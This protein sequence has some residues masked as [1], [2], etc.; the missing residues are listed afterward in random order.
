MTY[1]GR[2]AKSHPLSFGLL[3]AVSIVG[4]TLL[5]SC[6]VIPMP[7]GTENIDLEQHP[8]ITLGQTSREEVVAAL[9]EPSIIWET[10]RVL[11]YTEGSSIGLFWIVPGGFFANE[12]GDDILIMRFDQSDRLERLEKRTYLSLDGAFL[13]R[14]IAEKEQE[15]EPSDGT[16]CCK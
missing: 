9:G 15:Q 12:V 7:T 3:L 6:I 16:I 1:Q 13:R 2:G 5:S 11:V 8:T 10:E 4:A 14:W